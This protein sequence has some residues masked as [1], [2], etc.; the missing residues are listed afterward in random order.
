MR[1][2]HVYVRNR[3]YC[4]LQL[5][6]LVPQILAV[7]SEPTCAEAEVASVPMRRWSVA[8]QS[9]MPCQLTVYA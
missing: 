2:E 3:N 8:L 6:C 1:K 7:A 5:I 9:L 4:V